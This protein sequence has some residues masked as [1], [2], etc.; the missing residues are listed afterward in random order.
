MVVIDGYLTHWWIVSPT[1]RVSRRSQGDTRVQ[2]HALRFI[3]CR[4]VRLAFPQRVSHVILPNPA[5]S[6]A[7]N[8][9]Q[10]RKTW[11]KRRPEDWSD[12][13]R[14]TDPAANTQGDLKAITAFCRIRPD[15]ARD[16]YFYQFPKSKEMREGGVSQSERKGLSEPRPGT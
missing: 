5:P 7:D 3:F 15:L 1:R 4:S 8:Y 16:W 12:G 11:L 10:L 14:R 6:S 13:G 9:T 2:S